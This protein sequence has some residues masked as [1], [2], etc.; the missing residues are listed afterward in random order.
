M[1]GYPMTDS[2]LRRLTRRRLSANPF[3]HE[4]ARKAQ[5]RGVVSQDI[6]SLTGTTLGT[7][8]ARNDSELGWVERHSYQVLSYFPNDAHAMD[9]YADW[10]GITQARLLATVTKAAFPD[11]TLNIF[12]NNVAFGDGLSVPLDSIGL[13]ISDWEDVTVGGSDAA[14]TQW[15][16]LAPANETPGGSDPPGGLEFMEPAPG[17]LTVEGGLYYGDWSV[18]QSNVGYTHAEASALIHSFLDDASGWG[19]A[20]VTFREV[21]EDN[22]RV[23]FQVVDEASCGSP[24]LACTHYFGQFP[25]RAY[26]ELEYGPLNGSEGPGIGAGN[27]I[28]HEAGHAFF[29]LKHSG[30]DGIMIDFDFDRPERPIASDIASVE[31]WLGEPGEMGAGTFAV[32]L[33]Q[34]I[35]R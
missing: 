21:S 20:G 11:S 13:K 30:N 26:V 19:A 22:A 7:F 17:N 23:H 2:G 9:F 32:G 18:A 24:E 35:G 5:A 15:V 4:V 34:L 8:S 6:V 1:S 31:T 16:V 33:C 29:Y 14:L 25:W 12:G 27:V 10:S 3:A 28:N